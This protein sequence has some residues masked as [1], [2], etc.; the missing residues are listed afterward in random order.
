M[1]ESETMVKGEAMLSIPLFIIKKFGRE[2]YQRWLDS[3]LPTAKK[4][5]SRPIDKEEWF[6]LYEMLID[7]TRSMCEMF[8]NGS[9]RGAWECGR[10]SAEYSLKGIY[11][12]LVK[13]CSPMILIKKGTKILPSYYK[14][15]SLEII[16]P[17]EESVVVRITEFP[18]ITDCIE[19][20]IAGW[21]ERATECT[22]CKHVTVKIVSSL[23]D[24]DRYTEYR[25]SWKR[26]H[27]RGM[28]L[29]GLLAGFSSK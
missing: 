26:G 11:K 21:M 14:P 29:K 2:K 17:T 8:Y 12:V 13:L 28:T 5:Y 7:P 10:Y 9:M 25:V 3:L 19:H 16:D 1:S 20:R 18:G 22:G 15:T 24:H 27:S 23:A 6:P 4:I